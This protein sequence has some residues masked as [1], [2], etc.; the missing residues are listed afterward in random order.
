MNSSIVYL[1][2]PQQTL[3]VYLCS[4]N[5]QVYDSTDDNIRFSNA[6]NVE[7]LTFLNS[8]KNELVLLDQFKIYCQANFLQI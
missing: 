8:K 3:I 6:A 1:K 2:V 5:S 4:L 7:A